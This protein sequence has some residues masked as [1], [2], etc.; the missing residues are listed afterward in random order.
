MG[1]GADLYMYDVVFKKTN[2][3]REF[4]KINWDDFFKVSDNSVDDMWEKFELIMYDSIK[5]FIPTVRHS[6]NTGNA[7]K[8]SNLFQVI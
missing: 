8:I 3:L 7:K 5:Q 4:L 1:V 6:G 2:Q